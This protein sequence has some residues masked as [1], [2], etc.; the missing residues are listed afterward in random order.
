MDG[1]REQRS[2]GVLFRS[3]STTA[4]L[5]ETNAQHLAIKTS[6]LHNLR[7][8]EQSNAIMRRN[9]LTSVEIEEIQRG[10]SA[11]ACHIVKLT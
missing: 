3:R 11:Q 9:L 7:L 5:H 2:H 6:E 4:W 1:H 8:A 10:R